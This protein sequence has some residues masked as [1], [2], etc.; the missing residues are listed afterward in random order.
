MNNLKFS[1]AK[2]LASPQKKVSNILFSFHFKGK[3]IK[4]TSGV[5]IDTKLWDSKL[6][7]V[8]PNALHSLSV[9]SRLNSIEKYINTLI[10]DYF[11]K[12]SSNSNDSF[13]FDSFKLKVKKY[14]N[15]GPTN[16][17]RIV[18]LFKN[19][20]D[21]NAN[22]LKY[23]SIISKYNAIK[24]IELFETHLNKTFYLDDINLEWCNQIV[25][26]LISIGSNNN[27]IFV[28]FTNFKKFLNDMIDKDM[29]NPNPKVLKFKVKKN[30]VENFV[31]TEEEITKIENYQTDTKS[32]KKT[33]ALFMIQILT[34]IRVS[35]LVKINKNKIDFNNRTLILNTT[36]TDTAVIIP[37]SEKC[38]NYFKSLNSNDY[39]FNKSNFNLR[40]KKMAKKI[41]LDRPALK[42]SYVGNKRLE[43]WVPL[44]EVITSHTAR[45]T[46][47]T[48]LIKKGL[49]PQ[50]IMK[51]TG[52][53]SREAFDKYVKI[54]QIEA[55]NNV[56]NV[57]NS[58]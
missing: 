53:K 56:R 3:R 4:F 41:N 46:F 17:E 40:I 14:I 44:H 11:I 43:E 5:S 29:F 28:F 55:V 58:F 48:R 27:S 54:S 20:V 50:T 38:I 12:L 39:A 32:I 36:K 31:L 45:R 35:D 30:P 6:Q 34:G 25:D 15:S 42:V 2:Y 49:P 52:H 57:M 21:S 13:D 16:N 33:Q 26:F 7:K 22:Q 10:S 37:I 47:I 19:H 18:T 1:I 23:N 51:V 24:K 9:N 8:K